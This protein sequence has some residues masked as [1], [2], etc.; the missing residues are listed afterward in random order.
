[1][2]RIASQ[3]R[4]THSNSA[5]VS[6]IKSPGAPGAASPQSSAG[7]RAIGS[8]SMESS[9]ATPEQVMRGFYDAFANNRLDEVERHYAPDVRF[10]D[11]IFEYSDR[12]GTMGMWRKLLGGG[13]PKVRF[14]F[15][16]VEGDV[17]YGRWVADYKVF[18]RKVRNE[19]E[20]RMVIRDGKIV[21]HRDSFDWGKWVRQALPL[22]ALGATRIGGGV[23]KHLLR[24]FVG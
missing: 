16:R 23:I 18:G 20:A 2:T 24:T 9:P 13:G 10:K 3:P 17:A 11:E 19:I 14:T 4:V 22:G 12:A 6:P 7:A 5:D 21:E 8:D 1:M 15:D